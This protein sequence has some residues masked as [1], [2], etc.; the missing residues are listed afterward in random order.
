M[1]NFNINK[2]TGGFTGLLKYF[3]YISYKCN[4]LFMCF[5]YMLRF[6]FIYHLYIYLPFVYFKS[7]H[8]LKGSMA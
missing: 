5:I 6:C 4:I 1:D 2:K 3:I 7:P 8:F